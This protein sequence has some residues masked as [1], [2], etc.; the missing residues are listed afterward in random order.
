MKAFFLLALLALVLL[1]VALVS[2]LMAMRLAV[3]GQE[4]IVP[5]LVGKLPS[6]ARRVSEEQGFQ[7]EVER[8]YYSATTPENRILSQAPEAGTRV[9]RGWQI[10]VALSLGP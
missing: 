4:L 8:R 6:E 7:V 9:R 3:H 2:A 5:D 1:V 10:R